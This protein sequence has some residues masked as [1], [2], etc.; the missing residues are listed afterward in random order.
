MEVLV[1][2][3]VTLTN[4]IVLKDSREKGVKITTVAAMMAAV[5]VKVQ[6]DIRLE[7]EKEVV[8]ILLEEMKEG[9]THHQ[10]DHNGTHNK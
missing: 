4:V 5:A 3:W 10:V 9:E 1:L 2:M 6:E 8:E 7:E